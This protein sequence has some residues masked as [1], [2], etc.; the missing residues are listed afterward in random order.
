MKD[1]PAD[2][3]FKAMSGDIKK[4]KKKEIPMDF[5]R[6]PWFLNSA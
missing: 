4:K 2:D 3:D 6:L 1:K 5:V